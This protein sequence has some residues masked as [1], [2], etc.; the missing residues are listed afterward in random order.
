MSVQSQIENKIKQA[1]NCTLLEVLNESHSHNVPKGSESHF[2]VLAVSDDFQSL[3]R[4]NR[5]RKLNQLLAEELAGPVHALSLQLYTPE[6]WEKKAG[7][8]P[9]SPPCFGGSKAG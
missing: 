9:K 3:N 5:H 6:E 2:K 4:V 8:P 7:Q 1:F